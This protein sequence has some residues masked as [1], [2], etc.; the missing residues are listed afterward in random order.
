MKCVTMQRNVY[1]LFV[2]FANFVKLQ[3]F[4]I[5]CKQNAK[6]TPKMNANFLRVCIFAMC[7]KCFVL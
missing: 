4:A 1:Q 6:K 5:V 2:C 7:F 3:V